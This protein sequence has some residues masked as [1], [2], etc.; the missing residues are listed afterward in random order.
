MKVYTNLLVSF[1]SLQSSLITVRF[2]HENYSSLIVFISVS[3][4]PT[5]HCTTSVALDSVNAIL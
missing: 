5:M 2:G 1:P 3:L 4:Q